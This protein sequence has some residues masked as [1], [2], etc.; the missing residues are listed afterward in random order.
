[1]KDSR[2][3]KITAVL[4]KIIEVV[5]YCGTVICLIAAVGLTLGKTQI[6]EAYENSTITAGNITVQGTT[7][8]SSDWVNSVIASGNAAYV[9]IPFAIMVF[10]TALIF[11]NVYQ[12][13]KASNTASPFSME[14][15]KRIRN[16]GYYAIALPIVKVVSGVICF[17]VTK[18]GDG[19]FSVELSEVVFGLVA[20][21]LSQYFAY[22][23]QLQKDVDGLL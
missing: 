13:F 18:T 23:A 10:L 11:R 1:M 6:A 14:N 22:G 16:I 20:L 3:R 15:V 19:M 4:A 7:N 17:I 21:C 2:L 12:V 9:F 8:Y 5:G